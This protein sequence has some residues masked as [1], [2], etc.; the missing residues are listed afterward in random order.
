MELTKLSDELSTIEKSFESTE[1]DNETI[2][3]AINEKNTIVEKET[4]KIN[5][6]QKQ[7]SNQEQQKIIIQDLHQLESSFLTLK[8]NLISLISSVNLNDSEL[9]N[10]QINQFE[11]ELISISSAL[12]DTEKK[13]IDNEWSRD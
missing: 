7:L 1:N 5:L 13:I 12:G 2:K 6:L 3:S 8:D 9:I 11:T 10:N 4:V